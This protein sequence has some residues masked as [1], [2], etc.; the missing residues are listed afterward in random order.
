[1]ELDHPIRVEQYRLWDMGQI[2][3]IRLTS[4]LVVA[5]YIPTQNCSSPRTSSFWTQRRCLLAIS[6][7][8]RCWWKVCCRINLWHGDKGRDC[9]CNWIQ[10]HSK[11][12]T[13]LLI[14]LHTFTSP[15]PNKTCLTFHMCNAP[16]TFPACQ[17][18]IDPGCCSKVLRDVCWRFACDL[19]QRTEKIRSAQLPKGEVFIWEG[20]WRGLGVVSVET[21]EVLQDPLIWLLTLK[22]S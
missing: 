13:V 22:K 10:A 3:W 18:P 4:S 19:S 5:S 6:W 15:R 7:W 20:S 9:Y 11:I 16:L 2:Q 12:C 21:Y 1:M 8:W 17:F 14:L